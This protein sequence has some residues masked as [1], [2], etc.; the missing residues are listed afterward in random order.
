VDL[1]EGVDLDVESASF[2]ETFLSRS[3]PPEMAVADDWLDP[4]VSAW[5][6]I[7][8]LRYCSRRHVSMRSPELFWRRNEEIVPSF[9]QFC[10]LL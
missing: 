1:R 7:E 5:S 2:F 4:P 6:S 10:E 8:S 3:L 9:L